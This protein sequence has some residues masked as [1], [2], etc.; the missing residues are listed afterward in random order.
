MFGLGGGE[1][2]VIV[3]V[4]LLVFGPSKL[5]EIAR[6]VK[7]A[8]QEFRKLNQQVSKTVN[9]IR[10]DIDLNLDLGLE[11]EPPGTASAAARPASSKSTS[12]VDSAAQSPP[13]PSGAGSLLAAPLL[14]PPEGARAGL[15]PPEPAAARALNN[16]LP[17][18]PARSQPPRAP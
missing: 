3:V 8:Y 9:E 7:A 18:A 13:L 5:P 15:R 12:P 1:I 11:D 2:I 10:Q 6:V 4:A 14:R 17:V 16:P